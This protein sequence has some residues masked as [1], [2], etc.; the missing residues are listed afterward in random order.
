MTGENAAPARVRVVRLLR[1]RAGREADFVESYQGVLE[2]AVRSPG[3]LREQ[4]CRS[5]DDPGQWLLT[6]EWESFEAIKRW[7][8]DPDH[9]ALVEPMNACLHDDRWTGVFEIMP[10]A[11]GARKPRRG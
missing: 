11:P 8:T 4:L 5:V 7:R 1:V 9:A 2:R 10:E 3:H 6:S